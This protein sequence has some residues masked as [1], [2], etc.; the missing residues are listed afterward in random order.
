MGH[1]ANNLF[2][3]LGIYYTAMLSVQC[4][5]SHKPTT[6][7]EDTRIDFKKILEKQPENTEYVNS[8]KADYIVLD[9]ILINPGIDSFT[10]TKII[11]NY[12]LKDFEE[13]TKIGVLHPAKSY[14]FLYTEPSELYRYAYSKIRKAIPLQLLD[15]Q[16]PLFIDGQIIPLNKS[17]MADKLNRDSIR[18]IE[19]LTKSSPEISGD[20]TVVY[21]AIKIIF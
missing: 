3:I 7:P 1:I 21:G 4:Q 18:E 20:S 6:S 9:G 2:I 8:F 15:M 13:L 16:F 14:E 17:V 5:Q 12:R 11:R 19:F 10:A